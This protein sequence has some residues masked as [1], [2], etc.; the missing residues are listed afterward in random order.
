MVV[1]AM[2]TGPNV[3]APFCKFLDDFVIPA[4]TFDIRLKRSTYAVS[5]S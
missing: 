3:I 4:Y 1:S 2:V 5:Y